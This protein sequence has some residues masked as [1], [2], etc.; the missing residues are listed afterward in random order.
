MESGGRGVGWSALLSVRT[1][2]RRHPFLAQRRREDL[3]KVE[4]PDAMAD[5]LM[6]ESLT[7]VEGG[8]G[9]RVHGVIKSRIA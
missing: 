4:D 9:G 6:S 5:N 3:D 8:P 7:F 1:V 2:C